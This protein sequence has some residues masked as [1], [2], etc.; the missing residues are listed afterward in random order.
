[1]TEQNPAEIVPGTVVEFFEDKKIL[2]G[3]CLDNRKQRLAVLTEQNREMNLAASRVLH[4]GEKKL[5]L[6]LS[7]DQ[8][9]Q[10]LVQIAALRKSLMEQVAVEQLWSLVENEEQ[11][12]TADELTE[13]VFN[14]PVTDDHVTAVLRVLLADPFFFKFKGGQF[15]PRSAERISQLRLGKERQAEQETLLQQ[16]VEW[17]QSV[18]L[19]R[20]ATPPA[21]EMRDRLI[22][23]L[24][25]YCLF[26]Q[27]SADYAFTRELLKRANIPPGQ[28]PFRL[29][30]RLGIWQENENLYLHQHGICAHFPESVLALAA[31]RIQEHPDLL[32]QLADRRDLR[33]L[34]P[35]TIDSSVTRDYDDALS[36]ETR[37]GGLYELGVHIA[38]AAEYVRCGDVLDQ[39]AQERST[40]IYL[41]DCRIPMLPESLSEGICSLRA[42]KDRLALSFIVQMDADAHIQH[43]EI[44]PSVVKIAQQISYQEANGRLD[45]EGMLSSLYRLSLKLREQRLE[46][47]A[48]I[49][50]VPEMRVWVNPEGMIQVSRYERESPSQII[51]SELMILAN[52]LA[53]KWLAEKTIPGIFRAQDECRAESNPVASEYELFHIYRRRRLFAR[54]ELGTEPRPHCSLGVPQ[55]TSVSSPIRRYIDL[56]VQRQLKQAIMTGEPLY[57]EE[58]LRQLVTRLETPQSKVMLIRRKWTRYWILKYLEQEDIR[59]LDALVLDQG[60]RYAHLLLPS[61]MIETNMAVEEKG[62]IQAGEMVRVKVEHLNPR[63]D[64]LKVKLAGA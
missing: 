2:C 49:L 5:S 46:R 38:D 11:G 45:G 36:L 7:R 8:M 14:S 27:E 29:L 43:Y 24:K 12:F 47:G 41:P 60:S 55:Y 35:I 30:V 28:G 6:Q 64:L 19:N 31:D 50:P 40:S 18:W 22:E 61:Y 20:S 62:K 15:F 33:H 37:N 54:A 17:L 3:L 56:V 44:V 58:E 59:D 42:G 34:K 53:A 51:V 13:F 39:D 21:A 32:K 9:V 10:N 16:G 52:A 63:E 25:D 4:A 1:M 48:I 26:G 57:N 23:V